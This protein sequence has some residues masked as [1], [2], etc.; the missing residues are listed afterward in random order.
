MCDRKSNPKATQVLELIT[1][2]TSRWQRRC[3]NIGKM[4]GC[5]SFCLWSSIWNSFAVCLQE[6]NKGM[7][8]TLTQV[9][10]SLHG[11][12]ITLL[13]MTP[14]PPLL[15]SPTWLKVGGWS[16]PVKAKL[17]LKTCSLRKRSKTRG[18]EQTSQQLARLRGFFFLK[19]KRI[20]KDL[21]IQ[22]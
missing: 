22:K 5:F 13:P 4:R 21:L 1:F 6:E 16:S 14:W 7:L 19:G 18:E 8:W 17:G 12:K 20:G 9:G 10:V 11:Y 15:F 2:N 3:T